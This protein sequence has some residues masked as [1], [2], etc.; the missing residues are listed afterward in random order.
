MK[1]VGLGN[2]RYLLHDLAFRGAVLNTT[3]FAIVYI[4]LQIPLSLGLAVLLNN[5]RITGRK[6][7]RFAFFSSHLV[8]NVFV[9]VIFSLLLTPR[10]GLINKALGPFIGTE[11][12]WTAQPLLAMPA[13]IMAALW[14]SVGYG[15]IYFL[16]VDAA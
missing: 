16:A 12:Q 4:L 5:P 8:G 3:Y 2:Y 1:F 10:H 9:A 6:F 11:T 14:L 13:I 15:M 7:L